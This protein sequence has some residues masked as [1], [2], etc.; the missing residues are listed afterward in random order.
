MLVVAI[1]EN[2]IS[3]IMGSVI[4]FIPVVMTADLMKERQLESFEIRVRW[5]VG[6]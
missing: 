5:H 6:S 2:M 1:H 3:E 4:Q